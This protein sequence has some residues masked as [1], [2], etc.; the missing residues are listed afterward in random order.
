MSR[1]ASQRPHLDRGLVSVAE[2]T[3]ALKKTRKNELSEEESD[4]KVKWIS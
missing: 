2:E 3:N 1:A 4:N